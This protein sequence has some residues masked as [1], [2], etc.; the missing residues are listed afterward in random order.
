[1]TYVIES[2]YMGVL[3]TH[4]FQLKFPNN[5]MVMIDNGILVNWRQQVENVIMRLKYRAHVGIKEIGVQ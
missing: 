4:K 3:Y 1:M 5:C 2:R